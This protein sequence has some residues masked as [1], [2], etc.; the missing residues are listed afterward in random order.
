MA[1]RYRY[2]LNGKLEKVALGKYPPLSLKAARQKR[3]ELAAMAA[4]GQIS[5]PQN[6]GG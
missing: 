3:G 4:L 2:R 5:G 6:P 1:W